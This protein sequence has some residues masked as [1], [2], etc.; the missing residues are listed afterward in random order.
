M[1]QGEHPAQNLGQIKRVNPS[2]VMTLWEISEQPKVP[3]KIEVKIMPERKEGAG[4]VSDITIAAYSTCH[5]V[6]L[7][8]FSSSVGT[9]FFYSDEV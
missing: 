5:N 6:S 7:Y 3:N 4:R 9:T 2:T 8:S 1:C